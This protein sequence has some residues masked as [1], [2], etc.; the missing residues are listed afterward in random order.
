MAR[1]R[2]LRDAGRPD[3]PAAVARRRDDRR[4]VCRSARSNLG[5]NFEAVSLRVSVSAAA[6]A[7][8]RLSCRARDCGRASR[9]SRECCNGHT[10]ARL[11][12]CRRSVARAA[13]RRSA[14]R[15][16]ASPLPPRS[17]RLISLIY[18]PIRLSLD[19][20]NVFKSSGVV[21]PG[22][23]VLRLRLSGRRG[24]AGEPC[25]CRAAGGKRDA[26]AG[27]IAISFLVC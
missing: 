2:R 23:V 7:G 9:R 8:C 6:G 19:N 12:A 14:P 20:L 10:T 11:R 4:V 16:L 18:G 24:Q 26:P 25:R 3:D 21:R 15:C 1:R 5:G 13:V 27:R 22:I 17:W